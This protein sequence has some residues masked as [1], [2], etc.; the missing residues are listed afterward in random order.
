MYEFAKKG[1]AG[2][3]AAES[4]DGQQKELVQRTN[5]QPRSRKT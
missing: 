5:G 3:D 1:W 4:F 2:E